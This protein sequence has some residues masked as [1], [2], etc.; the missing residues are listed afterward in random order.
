MLTITPDY[1]P[2]NARLLADC[3]RAA[4]DSGTS[5]AHDIETLGLVELVAHSEKT[6][7]TQAFTAR[8]A[9][10]PD[11]VVAFRGT[12][13]LRDWITDAE[14]SMQEMG[15]GA[16]VHYGFYHAWLSIR[17]RVIESLPKDKSPVWFAGHSLGGALAC[18]AALA[19]V[20]EGANVAGV[21]T[22]G[23]PRVGD[24]VWGK[25]FEQALGGKVYRLVN[26]EDPVPRMPP[27]LAGFRH[28]GTEVFFDELGE[29]VVNPSLLLKLVSDVMGI[30]RAGRERHLVALPNHFMEH[31]IEL[32]N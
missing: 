25:A 20:S 19:A 2:E 32:T 22:F 15:D 6:T 11:V 27:V 23:Q 9:G 5:L 4:Y 12:E 30:V 18:L 14:F 13:S 21:Y 7:D 26:R 16:K 17:Q 24:K 3:S 31:Y 10:C 29:R 1:S 28:V 8:L